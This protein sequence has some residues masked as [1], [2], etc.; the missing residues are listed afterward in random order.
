MT[1]PDPYLPGHGDTRYRVRHYD[2]DLAYK[3]ATNR[4]DERAELRIE[5]REATRRIKLDLWG[6]QA[7]RVT[8]NGVRAKY[9]TTADG[10]IVETGPRE[11]GDELTVAL[12]VSGK[13]RMVPGVHGEAGWEELTDGSMVGAQPQGA[14]SWFPCNNDAA[15]KAT[16]RI[17][18][19]ADANYT[20]IAN[21]EMTERVRRGGQ[22]AWTYEMRQPMSPYLATV[23]IGAYAIERR[24]A[25]VPVEIVHPRG[26]TAGEK[27][28]FAEQERMVDFFAEL[29]GPYPFGEYRAVIVG[30][31]LEIP[32]EAQGLST[33]GQN[34]L[35]PTWNH[36]RLVAHELAHQWFGNSL[37]AERL[38]DMW[39]HEGFACYS[40]WLW[41]HRQW[42]IQRQQTRRTTT[43]SYRSVQ[44]QAAMHYAALE[45]MPAG[46]TLAAPGMR[47]LFDDWLYKR[48][49]L[50]VHAIRCTL[51]D[52]PFFE[53]LRAWTREHAGGLV[54]TEAFLAHCRE[55][56]GD[57][58]PE[59]ER[60]LA[61]WLFQP[62]L[63]PLPELPV[64]S[65]P[66]AGPVA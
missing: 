33:F 46:A 59:L 45:P 3:V 15:D 37:T 16:Y 61:A 34:F 63:P 48:G 13:P 10:V 41:S 2:L 56:A 14:P 60:V 38:Q 42:E 54:S 23:Q 36:E 20:V 44:D 30:D 9:R 49:A 32:L 55:R 27:T 66:P 50:T 19:T 25:S 65:A 6:L 21:G 24:G 8:V 47:H 1:A 4:L 12:R 11:P 52:E 43:R 57:L 31:A 17:T 7:D 40:E 53:L 18:V 22:M 35:T 28:A 51:G 5:I 39:L 62:E 26:R 58:A 29:F 64:A